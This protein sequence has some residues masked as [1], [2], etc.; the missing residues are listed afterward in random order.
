M[1]RVTTF[2]LL[3]LCLLGASSAPA[4]AAPLTLES[5][6]AWSLGALWEDMLSWWGGFAVEMKSASTEGGACTDPNGC[7]KPKPTTDGGCTIDP[8]GCPK[9]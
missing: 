6:E 7:P 2:A 9:P 5:S 1:K 8:N 4:S 3:L